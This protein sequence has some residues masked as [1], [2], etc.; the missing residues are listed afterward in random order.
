MDFSSRP[1]PLVDL[2]PYA[3]LFIIDPEAPCTYIIHT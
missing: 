3:A 1:L 2:S